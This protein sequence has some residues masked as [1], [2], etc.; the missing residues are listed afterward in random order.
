MGAREKSWTQEQ[1]ELIE[2]GIEQATLNL[3][4]FG[5]LHPRALERLLQ[6]QGYGKNLVVPSGEYKEDGSESDRSASLAGI[7]MWRLL[8]NKKVR[9]TN[10]KTFRLEGSPV[11]NEDDIQEQKVLQ[12][13]E[14]LGGIATY[15]NL[16]HVLFFEGFSDE[17]IE[18]NIKKLIKSG[19]IK[20]SFIVSGYRRVWEL[21]S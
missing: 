18:G 16:H 1:E 12:A 3:H 15:N 17:S 9:V 6:D 5:P 21:R 20:K 13:L 7:I 11:A 8:D 2:K 10:E 4:R 19:K 14:G